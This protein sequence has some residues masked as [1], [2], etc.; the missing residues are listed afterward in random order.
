MTDMPTALPTT[1]PIDNVLVLRALMLGDMLCATPA[2]RALRA[3]LPGARISL[4]GLPW[5]REL[6]ERLPSVD[7]FIEFP[8]WPGLP[9]RT[10]ADAGAR[11]QFIEGLR[12][13]PFDLAVQLHGSGAI[14]NP[15]VSSVGARHTTGFN[16]AEGWTP[17]A[18]AALF[19]DWPETGTEVERLLALTDHLGLPRRGLQLDFPLRDADRDGAAA[20]CRGLG[21]RPL[22]IVHAGAQLPSR[23]WPLERFGEVADALAE[24]GLAVVLTGSAAERELVDELARQLQKPAL[25]LVGSTSLWTLGALVERARV[26]VCNDTGISH[27]A[28]A[29]GTRSVV[30]A[31]GGDVARWAPADTRRHAVLWHDTPCRP[32]AHL[33]C[34]IGHPCA[35]G[36]A[37]ADV[38]AAALRAAD[39]ATSGVATPFARPP[40][41]AVA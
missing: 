22:A 26:V 5:A 12:R 16:H 29:L 2:L 3:A 6:A 35:L 37:V 20:L 31:S 40:V 24:A 41:S 1:G 8:G 23:R 10:A 32:C 39:V 4:V 9:E 13:R 27:L 14:V 21:E 28:A 7:E 15:L 11:Q 38:R 30:V 17:A 25:N 18:D 36:V 33:H 34:P 19:A